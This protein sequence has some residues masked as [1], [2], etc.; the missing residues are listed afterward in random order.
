MDHHILEIVHFKTT[1]N[2]SAETFAEAASQME[3]WLASQPGFVQRRLALGDDGVWTDCVEWRDMAAA[4]DAASGI[5]SAPQAKAM[6]A[7][8][9]MD[10]VSMKHASIRLAQ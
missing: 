8:I 6:L 3:S 7:L 2:A 9:A 5:G 4:Q 10:S 1:P